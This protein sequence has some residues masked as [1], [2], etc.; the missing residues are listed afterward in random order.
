MILVDDR[1]GSQ[2][3]AKPL[4]KAGCPVTL[5]RLEYADVAFA[6]IGPDGDPISVGIEIKTIGE[7][8]RDLITPRFS[9]HQL[10]GLLSS[11][12]EVYL[13]VEGAAKANP[14]NGRLEVPR[15]R[16]WVAVKLGSRYIPYSTLWAHLHTLS[17]RTGLQ[18]LRTYSRPETYAQVRTL[19]QWWQRGWANHR[20][21]DRTY[22]KPV[23]RVDDMTPA[24]LVQR[25]ANELPGI[26]Q[27][28][29][30]AV[31]AAFPSVWHMACAPVEEWEQI[32]GVGK[33]TA[34][35]VVAELEGRQ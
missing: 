25:V 1:Q 13:L 21:H 28:R 12:D 3:L 32:E 27:V 23:K 2:H 11:Y 34:R 22:R 7:M 4:E 29:S 20:S 10:P 26:G 17:I 14:F 15:A 9:G 24:T 6:G 18:L 35:K 33:E 5:G 19:Y 8:V 16:G 30:A 31:A